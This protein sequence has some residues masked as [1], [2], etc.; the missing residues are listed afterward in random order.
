MAHDI[1]PEAIIDRANDEV[2]AR[3]EAG[4]PMLIDIRPARQSDQ[5]PLFSGREG[6]R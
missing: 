6:V 5:R 3:L 1:H 4:K 2:C